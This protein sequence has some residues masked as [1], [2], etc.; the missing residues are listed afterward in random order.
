MSAFHGP[1]TLRLTA[2]SFAAVGLAALLA[3]TG[4]HGATAADDPYADPAEPALPQ[5]DMTV[6]L[7]NTALVITDP[8]IDFLSPD[9]VTWGVVGASVERH[10]TVPNL[11]RL[12]KSAKAAGMTVAISPHYYYPTDHGWKFGGPL[13]KLMHAIGMFDRKSALSV[14]GFEGSGADFMPQYKQYIEDGSTIISSPHKVYGPEQNDL[15]LQLRKAGID[16]IILAG[17]SANLCVQAHLHELLEDGFEVAVVRDA[18]AAAMLPE[19]DG[20]LAALINF[21]YIAN[22]LWTTDETVSRIAGAGS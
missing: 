3:W 20:Y 4:P 22:A 16:R 13:E 17:M 5:T 19:G 9:G 2:A 21:R 18:T 15:S 8:Q 12:M 7:S 11:E 6:D 1:V 14:E 10:N